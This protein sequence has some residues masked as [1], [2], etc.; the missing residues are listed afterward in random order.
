MSG[1]PTRLTQYVMNVWSIMANYVVMCEAEGCETENSNYDYR[2][3]TY[4]FECYKCGWD[5]EVVENG[6]M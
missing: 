5:N 1:I 3:G 2:N 4:W 6:A